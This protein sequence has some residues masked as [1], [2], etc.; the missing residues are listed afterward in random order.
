MSMLS[1]LSN[2]SRGSAMSHQSDLSVMSAQSQRAVKGYAPVS[3]RKRWRRDGQVTYA[4]DMCHAQRTM[5]P[6]PSGA[7]RLH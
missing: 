1:A 2:M 5:T 7:T 6:D 3:D 4:P